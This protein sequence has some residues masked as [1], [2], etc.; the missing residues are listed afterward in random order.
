MFLGFVMQKMS[1]GIIEINGIYGSFDGSVVDD[2]QVDIEINESIAFIGVDVT[3]V[4]ST[5]TNLSAL[6]VWWSPASV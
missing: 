2:V 6:S 1:S 3:S 5:H 4:V